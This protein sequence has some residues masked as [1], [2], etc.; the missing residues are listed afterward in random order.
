MTNRIQGILDKFPT[1][2]KRQQNSN[3]YKIARSVGTELN[4]VDTQN[5][6]LVL[7]IQVDTA[8][9]SSLNDIGRLFRLS[10][11]TGESDTDFR[12]RIKAHW[13]GSVGAATME[14]LQNA[15]GTAID[16]DPDNIIVTE[17]S[18]KVFLTV[19]IDITDT[20]LQ[21]TVEETAERFKA[22]GIYIKVAFIHNYDTE[23]I[24]AGIHS[25]GDAYVA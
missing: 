14:A 20:A 17:Q 1:F 3:N 18:M 5:L 21:S 10:R 25:A 11:N 19:P 22:A 9:G 16:E 15:I 24:P 23:I 8:S 7:D 6:N 13:Q 12:A 4:S 2:W